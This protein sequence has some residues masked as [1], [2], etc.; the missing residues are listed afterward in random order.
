[1]RHTHAPKHELLDVYT[2]RVLNVPLSSAAVE[3]VFS[4]VTRLL[5]D[6]RRNQL[7]QDSLLA[8]LYLHCNK[9]T[10]LKLVREVAEQQAHATG[11]RIG[12]VVVVRAETGNKRKRA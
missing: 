3:R 4:I 2:R 12:D 10:A 5:D 8:E 6:T 1:M 11:R 7:G 9:Q